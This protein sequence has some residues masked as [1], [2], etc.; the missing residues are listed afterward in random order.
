MCASTPNTATKHGNREA[1]NFPM[2][3]FIWIVSHLWSTFIFPCAVV[4][5]SNDTNRFM[6]QS[7]PLHNWNFDHINFDAEETS[8]HRRLIE[9]QLKELCTQKRHA[10]LGLRRA[11]ELS[12]I[13]L[14]NSVLLKFCKLLFWRFMTKNF[15]DGNFT[16]S[17]FYIIT[18][19]H[20]FFLE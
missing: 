8:S 4:Y 12:E 17:P 20:K 16:I 6:L 18:F 9:V 15:W 1:G 11:L 10:F 5:A 14:S 13:I 3:F 7:I 2:Q 19:S